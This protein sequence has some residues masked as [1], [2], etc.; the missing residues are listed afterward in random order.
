MPTWTDEQLASINRMLNPRSIAVVGATPS[1]QYGGRMLSV[2]LKAK[3]RVKVYPVNPRYDQI[4]DT[5][6]Y[7]SVLDL[8]EAPDTVGI[9]VPLRPGAGGS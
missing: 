6:C 4:M 5:K 1:L 7:P 3:N 9:V 8:P 2:A